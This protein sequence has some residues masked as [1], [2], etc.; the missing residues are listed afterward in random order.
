MTR[1][2][3]VRQE[4]LVRKAGSWGR[5]ERW[6]LV[7]LLA[8]GCTFTPELPGGH[9]KEGSA[10]CNVIFQSRPYYSPRGELTGLGLQDLKGIFLL[11]GGG[12]WVK[13]RGH[14][15]GDLFIPGEMVTHIL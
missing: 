12:W 13:P 5:E 2:D 8:R 1:I 11:G 3:T 6:H 10:I 4:K 7:S 9:S 14:Q 15:D